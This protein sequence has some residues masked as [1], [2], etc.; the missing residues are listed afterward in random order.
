MDH[1]RNLELMRPMMRGDDVEAVQERLLDLGFDE[2]GRADSIFGRDTDLG[3]RRF[4]RAKGFTV[5]GVVDRRTW[6]A[7]FET[8]P[9]GA[10]DSGDT[11]AAGSI[12]DGVTVNHGIFGS[13]EWRLAE[14]GIRIAGAVPETTGG[15]P[16]TV[17][18]VW[19]AFGDSISRWGAHYQVPVELIVAT[20]CQT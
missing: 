11:A 15:R 13:V 17:G 19:G 12:L 2:V 9:P 20:A 4:Q 10:G 6:V 1:N 7:L 8:A 16:V 5:N 3:A 18:R 14:D